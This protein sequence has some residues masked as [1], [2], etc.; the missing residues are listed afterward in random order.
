MKY[1]HET[2]IGSVL[3][4]TV[5]P[6]STEIV[7]FSLT[8]RI[9]DALTTFT[10][11]D[12]SLYADLLLTKTQRKS[13]EALETYI[14]RYGIA[15]AVHAQRTTITYTGSVRALHSSQVV[16]LLK[17]LLFEAVVDDAEFAKKQTLAL[18]L[19]REE[20]DN[21]KRIV[22]TLFT[23]A[24][25]PNIPQYRQDTLKEEYTRI[26]K[27][28]ATH[29]AKLHKAILLGTWY[30]TITGDTKTTETFLP[31]VKHLAK[32]ATPYI[33]VPVMALPPASI[34]H[35]QTV[36]SKTNIEVLIGNVVPI[37]NGDPRFVAFDFGIDVLGKT[38]G[39]FGRLMSTVREKEG[40]TYGI[41]ASTNSHYRGDL[42]HWNIR[43]FF[44]AK[45]YTKGIASTLR[46]LTL[47][48]DKG[49]TTHELTVFKDALHTE[50]ILAHESNKS[51]L[52]LY[53]DLK[54]RGYNEHLLKAY[55]E[56][57][58]LLTRGEVHKVLRDYLD[59]K[60]L[61][62]CAAGPIDREGT[63]IIT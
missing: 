3:F 45:D 54:R 1:T 57:V 10:Q 13:K 41:Y 17:E 4:T 7:Y 43:T 14:K 31:L 34:H 35:F 18:E 63:P 60:N 2:E 44:M 9:P 48:C 21:A 62:L 40:L 8:V 23:N 20:Y 30:V 39:F 58:A 52:H 55:H 37:P 42:F 51:R 47:L 25:Y 29:I 38:G 24:L 28:R 49:I 16:A 6:L 56:R 61:V 22:Q 12:L 53:H 32:T 11:T 26:E 15:L 33:H 27:A 46:E 19:N 59:P 50:Y 5:V 36:K